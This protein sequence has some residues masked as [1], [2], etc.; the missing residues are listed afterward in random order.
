L[1]LGLPGSLFSPDWGKGS[2]LALCT[3]PEEESLLSVYTAT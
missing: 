3:K 1:V 2:T